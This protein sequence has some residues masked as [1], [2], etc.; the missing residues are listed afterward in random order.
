VPATAGLYPDLTVE[1]NLA[2]SAGSYGIAGEALEQSVAKVIADVGLA[3]AKRRLGGQLSGG[4]Q[5]K[6]AVAMAL[7]HSPD[8]L[9]LD[10]PTT[11]VDPV[12][13]AEL[14]RL[15]AGAA[16]AGTAVVV[17]TTYVNEAERGTHALLMEAGRVLTGGSSSDIVSRVPG[18]FGTIDCV[19]Q[20]TAL[21]WRRGVHWRVW[22]PAGDLP[23]DA[24][25]VP[26][27][28]EDAAVIAE[29]TA[30]MAGS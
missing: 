5:R 24:V 29:L 25:P 30:E 1:E 9:V 21:S 7:V 23:P 20:P 19:E 3:V 12:S 28:I 16:A 22:A 4:M 2:F 10:E 13:R 11:G 6:L 26:P 14:W 15:I 17:A 8:L 27:D 18:A